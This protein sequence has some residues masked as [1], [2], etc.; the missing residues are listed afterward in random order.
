M[1][2]FDTT[3]LPDLPSAVAPDG[4]S[5]RALLR[6][7]AGSMA[8]F[9]LASGRTSK[10]V[11]HRTVEELWYFVGGRGQM[12]R[13][14]DGRSEIVDVEQGICLTIPLGTS[15]QFRTTG[16]EPLAA[17]GVTMPGWPGD[18]EAIAVKGCPDW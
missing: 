10:P 18:D 2:D 6:L 4:A 7:D 14:Q 11:R 17:I 5:V 12:W 16:S 3:R 13:S 9:E 1:S 15:F 8:H